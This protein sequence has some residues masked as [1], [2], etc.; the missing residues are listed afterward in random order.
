MKNYKSKKI[1]K[2]INNSNKYLNLHEIKNKTGA[3]NGYKSNIEAS[4]ELSSY[5]AT[6]HK[7]HKI[8]EVINEH[9]TD[10]NLHEIKAKTGAGSGHKHVSTTLQETKSSSHNNYLTSHKS[11][12]IYDV[13]TKIKGR[14][15][16]HKIKA[17]TGAGSG[18]KHDINTNNINEHISEDNIHKSHVIHAIFHN[19]DRKLNLHEIKRK[20]GAGNGH[21][22]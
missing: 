6:I 20:T 16:L 21:K 8:N 11:Q 9:G 7:S 18:Y 3:G 5:N 12:K 13:V 4:E 19:N 17:Q 15:N 14:A 22:R 1:F 2:I 10:L